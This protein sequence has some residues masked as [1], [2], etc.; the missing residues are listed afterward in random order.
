MFAHAGQYGLKSGGSDGGAH[1]TT[2]CACEC[3]VLAK[4]RRRPISETKKPAAV[5]G[6]GC[7]IFAMMSVCR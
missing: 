6:A 4:Q 2:Q 3:G 1:A 7:M 5:A